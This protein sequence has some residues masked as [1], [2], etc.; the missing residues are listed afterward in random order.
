MNYFFYLFS[1]LISGRYNHKTRH[2]KLKFILCNETPLELSV[3]L[4][5]LFLKV[6]NS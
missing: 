2:V 4:E 6:V 3:Y 5:K 1:Q